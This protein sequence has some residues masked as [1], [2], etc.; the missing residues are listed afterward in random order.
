M[1]NRA[2]PGVGNTPA[3][4]AASASR[5]IS[6]IAVWL[7]SDFSCTVKPPA[8]P[9]NDSVADVFSILAAA[10]FSVQS[11]EASSRR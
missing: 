4:L 1:I 7:P 6:A 3:A 10:L 8:G 9:V 11:A 5:E 2:L